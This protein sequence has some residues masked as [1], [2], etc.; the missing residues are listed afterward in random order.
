MPCQISVSVVFCICIS[1]TPLTSTSLSLTFCFFFYSKSQ[2]SEFCNLISMEEEIDLTLKLSPC[3]Q[4]AAWL[5]R[6]SSSM[7]AGEKGQ[8]SV[9]I[10]A[11]EGPING[12]WMDR[13]CSLPAEVEKGLM[14]F[15]D[16]QTMRRVKTGKRLL[17][18]KQRRAAA[19]RTLGIPSGDSWHQ[20]YT[21]GGASSNMQ[22]SP[23]QEIASMVPPKTMVEEMPM[24]PS[25]TKLDNPVKKLKPVNPCLKGDAMDILRQ[26]PSVTTTGDGP[27]G[28]KIE[29]LLYKY[30]RGQVCIV[31]V[32]HGSFLSPAEFVM[33]AGGKEVENPMKHITVCSNSF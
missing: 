10:G 31:C 29:G 17:L 6:S 3:G 2:F 9:E 19:D 21:E 24:R 13:T 16:L 23:K 15:G 27:S 32:C 12:P 14:R 18:E 5:T 20:A 7:G 25:D 30:R 11:K 8:S 28:K 22:T 26:M 1:I 4:N 33:H